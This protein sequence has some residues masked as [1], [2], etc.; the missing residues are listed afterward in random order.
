MFVFKQKTTYKLRISDCISDVGS[1]DR[2]FYRQRVFFGP[3]AM[4]A[5]D[6]RAQAAQNLRQGENGARVLRDAR[7][8]SLLSM[9]AT[10]STSY[11]ILRRRISAVSKAA[12]QAG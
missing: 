3:G 8:R 10:I 4:N 12:P 6:L 7:Y 11:L 2:S 1:S 9:M 5:R